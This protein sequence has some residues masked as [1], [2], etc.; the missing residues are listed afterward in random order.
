MA[1][2]DLELLKGFVDLDDP[3]VKAVFDVIEPYFPVLKRLGAAAVSLFVDGLKQQDWA[4]IDRE[5]YEQM[6]E[7]E[8]DAL[9]SQVLANARCAVHKAYEANRQWK[10]DITRLL[11]GVVLS[12]V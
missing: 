4:R 6:T 10:D 1:A 11:L 9:S 12:F 7:D 2:I 8:R 5:L 3:K